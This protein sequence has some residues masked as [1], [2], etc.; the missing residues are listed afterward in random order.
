MGIPKEEQG[1][2]FDRFFRVKGKREKDISGLGL[3]LYISYEIVKQHK[4]EI[5]VESEEKKG[6]SFYFTLPLG[7]K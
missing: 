4:G 6:S 3:G 1:K 7:R 2:I 5:W